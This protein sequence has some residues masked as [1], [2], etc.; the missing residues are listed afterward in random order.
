M[1]SFVASCLGAVALSATFA[2]VGFSA[3]A[4]VVP[5]HNTPACA[6]LQ[7]MAKKFDG[8]YDR[9]DYTRCAD[10]SAASPSGAPD[11][12]RSLSE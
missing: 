6:Q 5:S 11:P 9:V 7:A 4:H 8:Q 10:K 3:P 1:K 12:D 2:S